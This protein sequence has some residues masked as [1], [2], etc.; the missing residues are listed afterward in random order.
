MRNRI[1]TVILAALIPFQGYAQRLA[2][3]TRPFGKYLL[4]ICTWNLKDLQ[5]SCLGP[6]TP[7]P[8]AKTPQSI[9]FKQVSAPNA[10][11]GQDPAY[12][13]AV[14]QSFYVSAKASSGLP[15]A[16]RFWRDP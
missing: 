2:P 11:S 8:P 7:V 14:N 9:E 12:P 6:E 5:A 16:S 4:R 15:V 3:D 10:P 1:A 13:L